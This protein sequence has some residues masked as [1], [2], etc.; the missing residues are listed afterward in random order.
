[1]SFT[2]NKFI[3]IMLM[4]G[5]N[6]IQVMPQLKTVAIEDAHIEPIM[7]ECIF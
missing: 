4:K 5:I 1:M 2:L 3:T 7:T 6:P